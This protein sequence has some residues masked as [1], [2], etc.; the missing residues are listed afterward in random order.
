MTEPPPIDRIFISKLIEIILANLGNENFGVKE[1]AQES[2]MSLY[3]LNRRLHSI[4]RKT[5]SQ[6]IREA[7]LQKALELLQ[8][9]AYTVSE[10]AYKSGFSSPSYFVAC[11]HEYFGYPP[12]EAKKKGYESEEGNTMPPV[13]SKQEQKRAVRRTFILLSAGI[14]FLAAVGYLIYTV[15][16]KDF[17]TGS[18]IPAINPEKSIAVLPF[19]NLSNNIAD[20][21]FYDG[22]MEEI[23]NK[24]SRVHDLRVISRTSVEQYK[25]TTK[26]IPL[27][28]K[29]LDVNYIVEGSGQKFGNTF[30]LRINLI[31]VSTDKYI[32][33]KSYQQ[34]IK[35]TKKF[36]RTQSWIAQ[37]IAS[38]LKATITPNEKEMIEKVPTADITA[39]TLYLKAKENENDYQK[40]RYLSTF[41]TAVNLYNAALE[42]DTAFARAYTGL[43][44]AYWTRY[45]YETY[46]QRNFLDSV[47]IFAEKA[48]SIDDQLDEAYYIKGQYYRENGNSEEALKNYDKALKINPNYF[49]VYERK[50]Y[51]LTWVLG[52]YVNG[53]DNCLKALTLIRGNDRPKILKAL[54]RTYLDVGFTEKAKYYFHEALVLDGNKSSYLNN[55]SW[56]EFCL[57]NFEEALKLKKQ[58]VELDPTDLGYS[59]NLLGYY[60][61][62]PDRNEEA[63]NLAIRVLEMYKKADVLNLQ[64]S[65]RVGYIFWQVG[66]KKEAEGYFRQQI[67]YGEESIKLGRNIAQWGAAHYDLAATYSFLGDKV[68]A[69]QH[70]DELVKRNTFP[71]WWVT[72]AKYDLSFSSIRNEERFQKILQ[73]MESKY[74]SEHERV[75]KWLEDQGML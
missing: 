61:V 23:F 44:T 46:F 51:L 16:F 68:K 55:L 8:N 22:V 49:A 1:L 21:Y 25:N 42:I 3:R 39:Y 10:V 13:T 11:F 43:A 67:K 37:N 54:A 73:T 45:Y 52:D 9:E 35:N 29:E 64:R 15:F 2:G 74:H 53:L 60:C 12:G 33:A 31:E 58:N 28:G 32:W 50:W 30:R 70:L 6:F 72:M 7:R 24:L 40:T 63:Y 20:Q 34:R 41:Q 62:F 47:Q 56:T 36:F 17:S 57:A 69:Y 66:K 18:G 26:T 38:E 27:I 5:S 59:A 19:K 71:F 48:L 65:H 14:L 75:R 4:N